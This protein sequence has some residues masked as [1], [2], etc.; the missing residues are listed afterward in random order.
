[1][2]EHVNDV[3]VLRDGKWKIISTAELVPGDVYEVVSEQVVPVDA[4]I[5]QGDI[6]VDE[7][8]LTGIFFF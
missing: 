4:V 3:K 1:M 5:L 8:S 6:V 7:S 2:A